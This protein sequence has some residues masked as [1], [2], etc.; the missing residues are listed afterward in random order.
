MAVSIPIIA[1]FKGGNAFAKARK[2][3]AQLETASK[4]AG[5]VMKKALIPA[6]AALG[7]VAT[8]LF[9]AT[10]AA[11]EDSA[12]QQLLAKN[13]KRTTK[14]TDTQIAAVEDYIALQ[15]KLLGVTDDEL[16]PAF[17]KLARATKDITKAQK[18]LNQA[19][20]ISAATGKPLATVVTALERAYGG[21]LTAL[22][23][24][25]P[26]YRALIKDGATFEQ[27]MAKLANT[28]KGAASDAANTAAG[29]F[30]RLKTS[31]DET[32][33][34]IGAALL[35]VVE[36]VLPFLERF[37][38]WAA[39]NPD[40]FLAIAA[41]I[42]AVAAAIVAVNIA[43]AVNPFTAW[44]SA[45]AVVVV[46]LVYLYNKF[47]WF[48]DAVKTEINRWIGWIETAANAVVLLINTL[49]RGYNALPFLGDLALIPDVNIPRVR[50]GGPDTSGLSPSR[51]TAL[52]DGGIVTKPTFALIGEGGESEAVIPLSKLAQ[53]GYG[54]NG[55]VNITVQAGVGD[56]V[57]IGREVARV[58]DAYGRRNG[59][60]A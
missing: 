28:T 7:A 11:I 38:N 21:N 41:A 31:L 60:V 14:A 46:G 29:K 43:M 56:P 8:G 10:K 6:T 30:Q 55:G 22:G 47:T 1:E 53:M 5:F 17:A 50:S 3:F 44:A 45:I 57:A 9:D 19:L 18:L 26:E 58:M 52:A 59:R 48:S 35:P 23:R 16:R 40:E 20:D 37:A 36:K 13:L 32:K 15:G 2:E 4:K 27:V 42:S 34:S 24:L 54:G 49:I 39:E 33:E 51:A 12:A 25:A